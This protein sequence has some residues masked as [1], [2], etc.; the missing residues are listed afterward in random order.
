MAQSVE[1]IVH[2]D[3]VVGSS[4]TVT[5]EKYPPPCGWVFFCACWLQTCTG[6]RRRYERVHIMGRGAE[7]RQWRIKRRR[8][9]GEQQVQTPFQGGCTPI[10]NLTEQAKRNETVGSSPTVTTRAEAVEN[11]RL[12]L[13]CLHP[14]VH[15]P[16]VVFVGV[17]GSDKPNCQN[18]R[19][20]QLPES[21]GWL[22]WWK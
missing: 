10:A 9:R 18:C 20:A 12:L 3:G 5:T 1:H 6:D 16:R 13:L 2:I 15:C 19:L 22:H 7:R 11:Q 21:S 17:N 8:K 4:P 14:G